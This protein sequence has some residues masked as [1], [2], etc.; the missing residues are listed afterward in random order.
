VLQ[1]SDTIRLL[2]IQP[3]LEIE[4]KN[5]KSAKEHMKESEK[6]KKMAKKHEKSESKSHEKKEHKKIKKHKSY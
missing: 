4:M 5:S 1:I 3:I 6:H 2:T